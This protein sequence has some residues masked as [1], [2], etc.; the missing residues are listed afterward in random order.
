[1]NILKKNSEAL[2][3]ASKKL[4]VEINAKNTACVHVSSP[5]VW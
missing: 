5:E 3:K 2:L 4:C 1:M